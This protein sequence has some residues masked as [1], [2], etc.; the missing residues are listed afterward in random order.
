ME[1]L[2]PFR[3]A[4]DH[5]RPNNSEFPEFLEIE[6]LQY[7]ESRYK[8]I[9]KYLF[10]KLFCCNV[11]ELFFRSINSA[12]MNRALLDGQIVAMRQSWLKYHTILVHR[13][14]KQDN[15]ERMRFL[16]QDF[17]K[18]WMIVCFRDLDWKRRID[19]WIRPI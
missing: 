2:D 7:D 13:L 9:L 12:P 18:I 17:N 8:Y 4:W 11:C 10:S 5:I 16:G 1:R 3:V 14:C 6:C 19:R 15:Y